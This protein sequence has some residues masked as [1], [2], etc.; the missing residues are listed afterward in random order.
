MSVIRKLILT[1]KDILLILVLFIV[2]L[3]ILC[4]TALEDV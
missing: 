4:M 1:I 3:P 2:L